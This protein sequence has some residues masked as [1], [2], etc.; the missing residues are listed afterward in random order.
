MQNAVFFLAASFPKKAFVFPKNR[1]SK[2]CIYHQGWFKKFSRKQKTKQ[3]KKLPGI[4]FPFS[5]RSHAKIE[6]I[7]MRKKI[8]PKKSLTG[9][10]FLQ[11]PCQLFACLRTGMSPVDPCII[12]YLFFYLKLCQVDLQ[13]QQWKEHLMQ[14]YNVV[15]NGSALVD[16][17][18]ALAS[19]NQW[20]ATLIYRSQL[21]DLY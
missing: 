5:P 1:I 16:W 17:K 19:E 4:V 20:Y 12:Y 18:G 2:A 14:Q 6:L 15:F 21:A 9:T 3:Q 11:A 13:I 7:W 10:W 8:R